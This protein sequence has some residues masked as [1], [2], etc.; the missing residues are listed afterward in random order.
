MV[1]ADTRWKRAVVVI[2]GS[3]L[4]FYHRSPLSLQQMGK[5]ELLE[6]KR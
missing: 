1:D 3:A 6:I 2:L 4:G 5:G